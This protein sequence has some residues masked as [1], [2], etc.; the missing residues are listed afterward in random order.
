MC[1]YININTDVLLLLLLHFSVQNDNN[2]EHVTLTCRM[3]SLKWSRCCMT[4]VAAHSRT[5][6]QKE[7]KES[8]RCSLRARRRVLIRTY[9]INVWM[10][11]EVCVSPPVRIQKGKKKK[12][13]D[14]LTTPTPSLAVQATL[15]RSNKPP[16]KIKQVEKWLTAKRRRRN[17]QKTD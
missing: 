6:K 15:R 13:E 11:T 1:A 4:D 8:S 16:K 2:E 7:R 17:K 9:T 12:E 14:V 10:N 5:T 3:L